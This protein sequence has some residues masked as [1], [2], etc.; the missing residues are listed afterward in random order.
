MSK[1]RVEFEGVVHP[2]R[3]TSL[4]YGVGGCGRVHRW[5]AYPSLSHSVLALPRQTAS[6]QSQ[7]CPLLNC[8]TMGPICHG[9]SP[10][11]DLRV[12]L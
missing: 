4:T 7:Q 1:Q 12:A 9:R 8:S 3:Y 2:G 11:L 6:Q 5:T 10:W